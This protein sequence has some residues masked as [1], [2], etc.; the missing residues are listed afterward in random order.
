[1]KAE[2]SRHLSNADTLIVSR[3]STF[4]RGDVNRVPDARK[5]HDK[6]ELGSRFQ[7]DSLPGVTLDPDERQLL[8]RFHGGVWKSISTQSCGL[9][10]Y[11]PSQNQSE[12]FS[13]ETSTLALNQVNFPVPP[14]NVHRPKKLF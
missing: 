2:L 3:I 1:L 11:V 4:G 10:L 8:A 9:K 14:E 12:K 6:T 13:C 7:F 5:C